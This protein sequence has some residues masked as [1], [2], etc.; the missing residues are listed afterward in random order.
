MTNISS[1]FLLLCDMPS[2]PTGNGLSHRRI[3]V[4][5][6]SCRITAFN[7]LSAFARH[8][9]GPTESDRPTEGPTEFRAPLRTLPL[10]TP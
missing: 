3:W 7:H 9:E 5:F 1:N 8:P 2:T 10:G 6:W 4:L